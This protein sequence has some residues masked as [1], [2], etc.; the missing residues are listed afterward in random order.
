M[1]LHFP[2]T[3]GKVRPLQSAVRRLYPIGEIRTVRRGW[4]KGLRFKVMPAMGFTYARAL[5]IDHWRFDSLV[6]PGMCVY[7]IG[8]NYGQS[9]LSLARAVGTSGKVVAFEPV[10]EVFVHLVFNINLNP[11]LHIIP[12]CAAASDRNGRLDFLFD[13]NFA[14]QGHLSGVEPTYVLPS[15]KTVSVRSVR[16]DDYIQDGWPVPQF[17]KV[18]VEGGAGPVLRGAQS[19][20]A[21]HQPDI[22]LE[23]HGPEEQSA[24]RDLLETFNYKALTLTGSDVPDPAASWVNPLICKPRNRPRLTRACLRLGGLR[25]RTDQNQTLNAVL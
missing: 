19:L 23:L 2:H 7:D 4:L 15:A 1:L 18:D 11:S 21:K 25:T 3:L 20:I 17:V 24:V 14:S 13:A 10:E 6:K 22:Y 12:V 9:T 8:A 5:G 16:L